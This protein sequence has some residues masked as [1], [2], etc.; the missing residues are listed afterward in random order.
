MKM[1]PHPL[2]LESHEESRDFRDRQDKKRALG[3]KP[4]KI[5]IFLCSSK[6]HNQLKTGMMLLFATSGEKTKKGKTALFYTPSPP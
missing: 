5:V 2:L 1:I 3:T 4:N 6:A